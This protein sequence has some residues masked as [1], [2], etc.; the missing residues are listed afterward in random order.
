MSLSVPL[1][2]ASRR[3]KC[4]SCGE[5]VERGER[6]SLEIDIVLAPGE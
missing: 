3:L 2:V 1:V 4:A 6:L 5:G